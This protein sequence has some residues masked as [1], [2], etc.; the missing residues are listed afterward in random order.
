MNSMRWT[1]CS[2]GQ[3]HELELEAVFF[4]YKRWIRFGFNVEQQSLLSVSETNF[5]PTIYITNL[6]WIG[7]I[8]VIWLNAMPSGVKLLQ[9]YSTWL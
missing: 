6:F 1:S 2:L 3:P 8:I 5:S 4:W 9:G 7:E